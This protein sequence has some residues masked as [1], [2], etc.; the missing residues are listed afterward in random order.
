MNR[1]RLSSRIRVAFC[2][3]NLDIG[4]TELNAVRLAERL[5]RTRFDLRLISMQADGPLATRYRA[6]GVPIDVFSPGAL[7]GW[8]AMR[9]GFR[10]ST[11]LR[12]EAIEIFHAHDLYSNL[13]GCP[14]A[15][16]AGARV[17]ASRRWQ[18]AP[19]PGR[20]WSLASRVPYRV[21]HMSLAN[22]PRVGQMLA[23]FD[24]VPPERIAVV[25]NFV[26]EDAFVPLQPD[27]RRALVTELRLSDATA[28]IGIVANL[29]P[30][31]DHATL[32]RAV[33]MLTSRWPRL[34]VVLVGDGE[35]RSE[36]EPLARTLGIAEQVAF[37]GRR[38]GLPNLNHLFDIAV[39]CSKKEGFPNSVLEAMA[40]GVPVVATNVGAVPD[41]VIDG[42]TGM[43]VP[44]GDS[45]A[46]ASALD[47]LLRNPERARQLGAAGRRRARDH[48][49]PE[50][51]LGALE[52]LYF[53][54]LGLAD[55][56]TPQGRAPLRGVAC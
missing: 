10:L 17:I 20:G 19:L 3:D 46:L 26:D 40:A 1:G 30:V 33:A 27:L 45:G 39:L 55:R 24:R 49:S 15:R 53:K 9:E 12:R 54:L 5:D 52:T 47:A 28:V 31:K 41:A 14:W 51:A 36:L 21:A 6:A 23:E 8:R 29:R 32:L 35:S 48:Y 13:F 2:V 50:A 16:L 34:R 7:L 4:G 18:G 37:A 11:H 56:D 22:S 43:I 38:A 25:P 44:P 42:E